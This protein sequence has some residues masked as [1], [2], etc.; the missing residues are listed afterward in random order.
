MKT[1]ATQCRCKCAEPVDP[2]PAPAL[3]PVQVHLQW[4]LRRL[5]MGINVFQNNTKQAPKKDAQIVRV[6]ME[7]DDIVGRKDHMPNMKKS[8]DMNI[9]HVGNES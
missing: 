3:L 2:H 4:L 7:Q 1:V 8:E 5:N 6:T 9:K